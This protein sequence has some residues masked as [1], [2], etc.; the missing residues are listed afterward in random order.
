[1]RT[2][3]RFSLTIVWIA[4][5]TATS[6]QQDTVLY[7]NSYYLFYGYGVGGQRNAE[8]LG[9]VGQVSKKYSVGVTMN[10]TAKAATVDLPLFGSLSAVRQTE[11]ITAALIFGRI[12]KY[13][14]GNLSVMAGPS[15]GE[16][17]EYKEPSPFF[18]GQFAGKEKTAVGLSIQG[19]V[20]AAK[21]LVGLGLHSFLNVN[22]AFTHGGLTL[23]LAVGRLHAKKVIQKTGAED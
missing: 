8:A 22:Q 18:P 17:I 16:I 15:Y 20:F 4:C 19:S 9:I 21:R 6:A 11:T 13:K 3:F 5:Y 7:K 23:S 2:I 12:Q 14:W 10:Y 1:M